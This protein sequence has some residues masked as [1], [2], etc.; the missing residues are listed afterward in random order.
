MYLIRNFM[1]NIDVR[2]CFILFGLWLLCWIWIR[3]WATHCT[4][5]LWH[6][7]T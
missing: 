2:C 7:Y 3:I 1:L 4:C 5:C 6:S